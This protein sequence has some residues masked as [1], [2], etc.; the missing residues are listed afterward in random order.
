MSKAK[1][2]TTMLSRKVQF[3]KS[4]EV[5]F[6]NVKEGDHAEV[7]NVYQVDDTV[8]YDLLSHNNEIISRVHPSMFTVVPES[9]GR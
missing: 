5:V 1:I 4:A 9:G 2:H 3:V 8:M 7:V 6:N